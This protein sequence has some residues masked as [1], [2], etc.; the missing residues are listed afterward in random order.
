[1]VCLHLHDFFF[2]E[3]VPLDA[4]LLFMFDYIIFSYFPKFNLKTG[5]QK[6]LDDS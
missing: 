5:A 1:M 2:G 3:D 6:V 4:T